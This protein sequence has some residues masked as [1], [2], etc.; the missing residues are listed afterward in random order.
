M[1]HDRM[2]GIAGNGWV[3]EYL[4]GEEGGGGG[5]ATR[6]PPNTRAGTINNNIFCPVYKFLDKPSYSFL[7]ATF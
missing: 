2:P 3:F 5:Y 7:Y 6:F 1:V 4:L